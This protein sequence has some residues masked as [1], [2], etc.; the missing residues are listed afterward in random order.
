[1]LPHTWQRQ[2]SRFTIPSLSCFEI[3]ESSSPRFRILDLNF[4][5]LTSL[6]RVQ[7]LV[8]AHQGMKQYIRVAGQVFAPARKSAQII[9]RQ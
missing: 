3:P 9:S 2:L 5:E 7:T 1:M 6:L 8:R 4:P